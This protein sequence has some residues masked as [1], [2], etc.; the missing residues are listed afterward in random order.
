[1][2]M[3]RLTIVMLGLIGAAAAQGVRLGPEPEAAALVARLTLADGAP[4]HV[5]LAEEVSSDET[6][7]GRSVSF[8]ALAALRVGEVTLLERGASVLGA[9]A[10][11]EEAHGLK[12]GKLAIAITKFLLPDG[13]PVFLR[14]EAAP[15]GEGRTLDASQ[16]LRLDEKTLPKHGRQMT[17]PVGLEFTVYVD[18]DYVIDVERLRR[19]LADKEPKASGV[20]KLHMQSTPDGAMVEVDGHSAGQTPL[21][22]ELT[23]GE[24]SLRVIHA[25]NGEWRQKVN[26]AGGEFYV[27]AQLPQDGLMYTSKEP[28]APKPQES[29]GEAARRLRDRYKDH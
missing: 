2:R 10:E 19:I 11:A 24:H 23:P 29:L 18:G 14:A 8:E 6:A 17:L 27:N 15:R 9:V 26:L 16:R 1:M 28:P 12:R 20:T 4:L 7:A 21:I 3:F 13:R 25:G 22:L 5:R